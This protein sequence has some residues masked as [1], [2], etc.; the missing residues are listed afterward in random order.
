[1]LRMSMPKLISSSIPTTDNRDPNKYSG[2]SIVEAGL[3]PKQENLQNK[4]IFKLKNQ[5]YQCTSILLLTREA[6]SA[7]SHFHT[8]SQPAKP[9]CPY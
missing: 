9:K 7:L 5:Y 4:K 6:D 2:I 1:M 8:V 3:F